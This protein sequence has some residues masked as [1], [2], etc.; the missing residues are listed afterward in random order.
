MHH[1]A[2][3]DGALHAEDVPVA[4]IAQAIGTPFYCYSTATLERHYTVFAA[5]LSGLDARIYYALKANGNLAVVRTLARLG[6]GADIVSEGELRR[7]RTAGIAA[8][9]IV[10]SGVGKTEAEMAAALDAGIFQFNVESEPELYALDKVARGRGRVAPIAIR[11]N[12]EVAAGTHAKITTGTKQNK[13]G[14]PWAQARAVY[15]QARGLKGVAVVGIAAHIGSQILD[16]A[17]FEETFVKLRDYVLALRADGHDIRRL[18]VGGGL[19]I[20]YADEA[21]A[22]PVEYTGLARRI[23]GNLGCHLMFEPGR[24]IAGNAGI[25]VARVLYIKESEERRF[26]IVDAAMND[27]IRPAL[28]DAWHGIVPVAEPA[29]RAPLAPADVVGPVCESGDTFTLERPLPPLRTNDLL[30]FTTA[31]AYGAVMAS[32][33][34]SRLLVPE[35]AVKG[36]TFAVVRPRP[37][38]EAMLASERLPDWLA[39]PG[40][41]SVLDRRHEG[42]R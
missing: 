36:D 2:Y 13:F 19:G 27:L 17:P 4:R 41:T 9:A 23:L 10:F 7:A 42:S 8:D 25:L 3:R 20:P 29:A 21:P 15:G 12:P 22:A 35:V 31:G 30:A 24:L 16:L 18:D 1:F 28:Y 32:T 6:A 33:Y 40:P 11:V 26:V 5:G 38:Y 39:E 34:N 14:I 37:T